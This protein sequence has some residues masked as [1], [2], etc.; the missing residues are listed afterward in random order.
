MTA[1]TLGYAILS[2][3]LQ[4]P[5]QTD[6][7]LL[8][9][10]NLSDKEARQE[11]DEA[12]EQLANQFLIVRD[13]KK[14]LD[15]SLD[16]FWFLMQQIL[17]NNYPTP[18]WIY[19]N[20]YHVNAKLIELAASLIPV[21]KKIYA[22]Q[23]SVEY[24]Y[25]QLQSPNAPPLLP[26]LSSRWQMDMVTAW[27]YFEQEAG[28]ALWQWPAISLLA[29]QTPF[30]AD[31]RQRLTYIEWENPQLLNDEENPNNSSGWHELLN[32]LRGEATEQQDLFT[33]LE[34]ALA[35]WQ[36]RN[37]SKGYPPGAMT[38]IWLGLLIQL[39][40]LKAFSWLEKVSKSLKKAHPLLDQ[41][42]H[43][44]R[45]GLSREYLRDH[46]KPLLESPDE[47]ALNWLEIWSTLSAIAMR[48][49]S[50]P[51]LQLLREFDCST[52]L[53]MAPE[54][55][56][57]ELS[58]NLLMLMLQ[59][60][61]TSLPLFARIKPP[62]PW[63]HW[64]KTLGQG[65][66]AS[67]QERVVWILEPNLNHLTC[68]IQK[69]TDKGSWSQGRQLDSRRIL[70]L[71]D[72]VLTQ[73]DREIH[74]L[75]PDHAYHFGK[76]PNR[77]LERLAS[78]TLL[79]NPQGEPLQLL[80]TAP[81]LTIGSGPKGIT[82]TLEPEIKPHQRLEVTQLASDLWQ[83][84]MLPITLGNVL[85]KL[86]EMPE[87]PPAALP[88]L[89]QTLEQIPKLLW[90]SSLPELR[91]N[92][93]LIPWPG[94]P[95]LHL[96]WQ[97]YL[98]QLSLVSEG[99][100]ADNLPRLPLG[101][102][103]PLLRD[104]SQHHRFWQRD[105]VAEKRQAKQLCK[106][107]GFNIQETQWQLL[108]T[109]LLEFIQRLPNILE[110]HQIRA[111]W[112]ESSR[113]VTLLGEDDLELRIAKQQNWFEV[114][115]ELRLDNQQ[116]MDLR[117]LL[118]QIQPGGR[119]IQL[120]D[121]TSLLLSEKLAKRL[122]TLAAMLDDEQKISAQLAYPLSRL[123]ES[124]TTQGDA[125][126]EQLQNE[127]EQEVRLP[128]NLLTP[129]R[130]YQKEGANWL[131]TLAQHGFGACLADDMGLG[132][133][134]QALTLLRHRQEKGAALV[135]VPKSLVLNWQEEATRFA[136]E[137]NIIAL[138]QHDNRQEA[139][140]ALK[141]GD[142]VLLNYGLLGSLQEPLQAHH[143]STLIA[144]EAQQIKNATTQRAKILFTLPADFRLAL[145][146]TPVEN[147][148]GELWSLF[149]FIN[150]GL[151]GNHT[152]FKQRFGKAARD[153]N[154][155]EQ[156]RGVITPFVL[157]RLKRQVLTELPE[158]TEI[159][160]HI[161]LSDEERALYEANRLEALQQMQQA[162][163]HALM[164]L[165]SSLTRL[166][167]LCCSP[168]LL[169]ADWKKSQSKLDAAM[170]LIVDAIDNGHRL[171]VFSQFVELLSLLRQRLEKATLEYCYLDGSCSSK[172]RQE[173]VRR[174]QQAPVPLFLISLKA[175]GTGLNLTQADTVIHL[176]PWWNPAVED[177]ASD[178]AHRMG[179]TEP[180]TVYRLV[181]EG[182]VEEKIV[183]LHAEK[184]ALADGLLSDQGEAVGINAEMIRDLLA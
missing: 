159:V 148:L 145:S 49:T 103:T 121:K 16:G 30:A 149:N 98:L 77:L 57:M 156:L 94:E 184:R 141:A 137:L 15:I 158:K 133:T 90:H 131:A 4:R 53:A 170:E 116:V 88:A 177:Q 23:S 40:H 43:L 73:A 59:R 113:R 129:L 110:E 91:G 9:A 144:D 179:Q 176:D 63:E 157:R 92:V 25:D 29:Q 26:H 126:W 86:Q 163:G 165:L 118:R 60:G 32:L 150:P 128:T 76:L 82:C 42:L 161:S 46:V 71:S 41:Q 13:K 101:E 64:L 47:V 152:H 87:L 85:P 2:H 27:S 89:Q 104:W 28:H 175:G 81:L 135:I 160:H 138:D 19:R 75:Q 178:R 115:G 99:N 72:E 31:V 119:S 78:H 117:L 132:K 164:Q 3:L 8:Q 12:L 36:K 169:L 79:F 162:E 44:M 56:Q 38:V 102:G 108:G 54:N 10:L 84:T 122:T 33:Q 11:V 96:N 142:V 172:Q 140:T 100:A 112:H 65:S 45:F 97:D 21:D 62:E 155:M 55:L 146:G 154:H 174:F 151:L 6:P 80:L 18:E 105:L 127:W 66:S 173:A 106:I 14:K 171:L 143:W 74:A 95:T 93:E 114:S 39:D 147:H 22:S 109:E 120:D 7:E 168:A 83:V 20:F 124:I 61:N 51:H 68:K 139:L 182:T 34:N 67:Q 136:P 24:F 181:C 48:G 17:L 35:S 1:H 5:Q 125:G 130:D 37:K 111:S 166:R 180:V 123:L 183:A 70:E 52:L 134:L 107:L 167:R 69:L 153:A 50:S 58:Q